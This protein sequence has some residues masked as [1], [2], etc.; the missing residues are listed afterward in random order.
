LPVH[1][2]TVFQDLTLEHSNTQGGV[3]HMISLEARMRTSKISNRHTVHPQNTDG[4]NI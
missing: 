3:W 4:T 1:L 2:S